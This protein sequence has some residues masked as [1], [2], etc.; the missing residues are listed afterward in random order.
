[1]IRAFFVDFLLPILLLLLAR[2]FLRGLFSGSQSGRSS[3]R[4]AAGAPAVQSGGDLKR[5]PV[6][7]TYVSTAVSVKRTVKG[8]VIHFCSVECRNKYSQ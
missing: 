3:D 8:E 5:D 7:G 4:P 6:C 2:S 1:M